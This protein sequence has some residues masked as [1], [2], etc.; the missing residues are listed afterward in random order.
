MDYNQL[1]SKMKGEAVAEQEDKFF[2]MTSKGQLAG[3]GSDFKTSQANPYGPVS[4]A[5]SQTVTG[6]A[7]GE[8]FSGKGGYE[9]GLLPDGAFVILKSGR[10][11]APGTVVKPGMKGYDAIKSEFEM[12][13]A[14]KPVSSKPRGSSDLTPAQGAADAK[15]VSAEGPGLDIVN[16]RPASA[17][18]QAI[19][20]SDVPSKAHRALMT[21]G[22]DKSTADTVISQLVDNA[23]K[24]PGAL[25]MLQ[26][27]ASPGAVPSTRKAAPAPRGPYSDTDE[28][29]VRSMGRQSAPKA[30]TK[31]EPSPVAKGYRDTDE[32]LVRSMGRLR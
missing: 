6:A 4:T 29:L 30:P 22:M 3:T 21:S 5:P 14:G 20:R 12:V 23:A 2:E 32:P 19:S 25:D 31:S 28:P 1:K 27:L 24:H 11:A 8:R 10:G 9:Y 15:R 13:K 16:R 17:S 7:Q 26:R 18:A